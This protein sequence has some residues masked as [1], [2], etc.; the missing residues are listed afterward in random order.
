MKYSTIRGTIQSGDIIAWSTQTWNSL[1]DIE[2]HIIQFATNSIYNHIG[3]AWV[4]AGRVLLIEATPPLVR[5]FPLSKQ[6][7]FYWI[8][9]GYKYWNA[10][11]EEYL[12][13]R[14]GEEYSY[15]EAIAGYF[16]ALVTGEDEYWQ[17]S[18]LTN[19]VLTMGGI[20]KPNEVKSTPADNVEYLELMGFPIH[21]I[22]Q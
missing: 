17:C 9:C 2:N 11:I 5:I 22:E 20:F 19:K 7:P 13:S 8:P 15:M 12:L 18:E 21:F 6:L 16:N 4:V 1:S 10:N 3:V 14:V